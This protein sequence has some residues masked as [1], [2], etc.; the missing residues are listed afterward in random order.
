MKLCSS[1]QCRN[2]NISSSILCEVDLHHSKD[3]GICLSS[4]RTAMA[5]NR[6]LKDIPTK[7]LLRRLKAIRRSQLLHNLSSIYLLSK[8]RN[9]STLQP[10]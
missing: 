7:A 2:R 9:A 10:L 6:R 4:L 5:G 8:I 1:R 3:M